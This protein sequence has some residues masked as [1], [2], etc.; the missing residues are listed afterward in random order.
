MFSWFVHDVLWSPQ[1]VGVLTVA[2]AFVSG[3]YRCVASNSVGADQLDLH[4]YI[5][6]DPT[7]DDLCLLINHSFSFCLHPHLEI[8][9]SN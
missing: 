6:G 1:T 7:N 3:V 2:E 8:F 5:T 4:F 9:I